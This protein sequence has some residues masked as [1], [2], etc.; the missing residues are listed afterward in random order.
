MKDLRA[1]LYRLGRELGLEVLVLAMARG[2]LELEDTHEPFLS[3]VKDSFESLQ[4]WD[5]PTLWH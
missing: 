3:S 4:A 2:A 1:G 5:I